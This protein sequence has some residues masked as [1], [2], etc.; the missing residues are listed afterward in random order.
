MLGR[1]LGPRAGL[2]RA[3]LLPWL[4]VGL[5]VAACSNVNGYGAGGDGGNVEPTEG[6]RF[7]A[8]GTLELAPLETVRVEFEGPP[9][10]TVSLLLLGDAHDASLDAAAVALDAQGRGAVELRAPSEPSTFRL[11]AQLGAQEREHNPVEVGRL[12]L[13][14]QCCA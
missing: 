9:R 8:T 2:R 12:P 5:V 6:L 13:V 14:G 1:L 4:A 11:R 10:A 7:E 3:A